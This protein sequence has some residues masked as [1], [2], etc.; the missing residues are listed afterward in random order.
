MNTKLEY[1]CGAMGDLANELDDVLKLIHIIKDEREDDPST[2]E[3]IPKE[4]LAELDLALEE[5]A[6][7]MQAPIS[8]TKSFLSLQG[9]TGLAA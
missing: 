8:L 1:Q 5:I 9:Y 4:D 3:G 7:S 2:V 6:E